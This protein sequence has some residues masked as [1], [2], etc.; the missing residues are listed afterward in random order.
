MKFIENGINIIDYLNLNNLNNFKIFFNKILKLTDNFIIK[1]TYR[2]IDR[3][4][5]I[6][7]LDSVIENIQ[8]NDIITNKSKVINLVNNFKLKIPNKI[9]IICG[10]NHG[11]LTFSN[12]LYDIDNGIIYLIDF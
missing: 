8:K 6:N 4:K 11:D 2:D 9:S 12:I 7:K 5:F 1:S 3:N 10:F